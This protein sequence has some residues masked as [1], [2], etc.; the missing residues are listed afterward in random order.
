MDE[1]FNTFSTARA[2]EQFFGPQYYAK[3]YFGGFVPWVFR[4]LPLSRATDGNRLSGYRDAAEADAQS[5]PTLALLAGDGRRH[6]LQQDRALAEHARAHARLGHAAADPVDLL[7]ALRVQASRARG[8]LRGRQRGQRPRSDLVLRS[9]LPQL[10]R[11]RLRR[12]SSRRASR[13]DRGYFGDATASATFSAASA[14]AAYRHDASSCAATATASS[15]STSAVRSRTG[16][17]SAG[18][19]T[20]ASAGRSSKS[21]APARAV[22]AEV[23]PERVLLL[24]V[25]YTNNSPHARRRRRTRRR[26]SGR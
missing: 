16:R 18:S 19:G 22:S 23:D 1:G 5:T 21:T 26:A 6:H 7:R 13:A 9:G 17:S 24:D 20:A 25:N 4:D 8:L 14:A 15:R 10:E 2:I 11:L 12:P 3:R